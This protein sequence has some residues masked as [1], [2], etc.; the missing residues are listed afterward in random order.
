MQSIFFWFIARD[1]FFSMGYNQYIEGNM[2]D[3]G[4]IVLLVSIEDKI[5]KK[6]SVK[7]VLGLLFLFKILEITNLG[8]IDGQLLALRLSKNYK[9]KYLFLVSKRLMQA[10]IASFGQ[11]I[12]EKTDWYRS[13][14]Y[15]SRVVNSVLSR[16]IDCTSNLNGKFHIM[17]TIYHFY[18]G[19]ML[20]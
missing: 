9:E 17:A 18:Y 15:E 11:F 12:E 16:V 1:S 6:G 5:T 14:H 4:R 13:W 10:H 2:W 7:V 8:G 20:Q 19:F 3:T